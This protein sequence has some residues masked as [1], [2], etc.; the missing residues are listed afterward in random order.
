M[1]FELRR[2]EK[3]KSKL[4]IGLAGTSGSGKTYSAL[5]LAKGLVGD[6]TKV[7]V[8]DTEQGSADLYDSLGDYNVITLAAPFTP[9]RYIEAI[10]TAEDA[11]MECIILDSITHEWDGQG[12]I[13]EYVDQLT[14]ASASKN[15][16]TVWGKATPR[17][18]A[19]IQAILQSTAHII[20]TV[21]R[22]QDYAMTTDSSGK[23][24][25]EKQGLKEVTREGFEYELTLSFALTQNHLAEPSK[26]RTGTFMGNS[27]YDAFIITEETGKTLR[28]WAESGAVEAI[29]ERTPATAEQKDRL[30]EYMDKGFLDR[31]FADRINEAKYLRTEELLKRL[32]DQEK[33]AE[34]KRQQE[35]AQK[36]ADEQKALEEA[37]KVVDMKKAKTKAVPGGAA[38]SLHNPPGGAGG[39]APSTENVEATQ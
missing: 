18:N 22:K 35:A 32:E 9:E 2:A 20:T 13:L 38:G 16:Y 25:V 3:K 37:Q 29:T 26:D 33:A 5:L 24:K 8:V 30:R 15:S 27:Q 12:G 39:I 28:A 14:K 21:R 34:E 4:R 1:A 6:W 31:A 17:H 7:C 36:A 10:R 23:T 11:G 19:F